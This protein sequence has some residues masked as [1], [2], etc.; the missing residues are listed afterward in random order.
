M[1]E[2][3]L[4]TAYAGAFFH[5]EPGDCSV[6]VRA[7]VPAVNLEHDE[8]FLNNR[9]IMFHSPSNSEA[10]SVENAGG[11]SSA[12]VVYCNCIETAFMIAADSAAGHDAPPYARVV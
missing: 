8:S 10:I 11:E 3:V 7:D 4:N 2:I 6:T 5:F 12:V 1:P 9:W